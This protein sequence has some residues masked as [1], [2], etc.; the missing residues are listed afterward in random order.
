VKKEILQHEFYTNNINVIKCEI[1][2]EL[3]ILD[4]QVKQ[5]KEPDTC[6]KCQN[7]KDPMYFLINNLHPVW[8]EVSDSRE[9]IRD[10]DGN[11]VPHFERPVEFTRLSMAEKFLIRRCFNY[12][13]S[14]RLSNGTF[15]LKGHCATFPQDISAT[16]NK[17]PLCKETMVV[18]I[19]YIGNKDTAAVYP[20]SLRVNRKNV[21]EALLWLKTH[22]PFYADVSIR[23]DNLEWMQGKDEVSIASNAEKFKIKNS[24][25]FEIIASETEYVSAAQVTNLDNQAQDSF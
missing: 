16:C 25:Q 1:C 23:E 4:K 8:Y 6:Q 24:N 20:K 19:R 12:D 7:R 15:A 21:L 22:N 17:L 2:L 18:I 5:R 14:V 13:P 3:Q 10:K 9:F 11:L